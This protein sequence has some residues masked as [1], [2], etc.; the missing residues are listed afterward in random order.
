MPNHLL[1]GGVTGVALFVNALTELPVGFM[2][3][4]FNIP[5]FLLGFRDVGRRFALYSGLSVLLFWLMADHLPLP[6]LTHEPL[7]GAMFGGVISG[8]GS[9]LALRS[10]GSGAGFDILGVILNRRFSLGVG[11]ALLVLN[12][13]LVIASGLLDKPEIAMYTLVAIYAGSRALDALQS[14]RPRKTVLIFSH[15][16]RLIKERILKEMARGAT[17]LKAEGA[18]TGEELDVLLCVITQFEMREMRDIVKAEDPDAFVS[19]LE[20]S[21]VMGRFKQPTAFTV[22]K[23]QKGKG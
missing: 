16:S 17:I 9:F 22:W 12:G 15:R 20:A 18:Y 5:I 23:R 19:V 13:A 10:G 14:P 7:L 1:S 11:E 6:P 8:L 21:D 4:L 3:L 2:V